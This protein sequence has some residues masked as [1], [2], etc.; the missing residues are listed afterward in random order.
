MEDKES[1]C[2]AFNAPVDTLSVPEVDTKRSNHEQKTGA[3][4]IIQNGALNCDYK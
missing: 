2:G 3:S 4:R 1:S